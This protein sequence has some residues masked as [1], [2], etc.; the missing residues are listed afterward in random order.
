MVVVVGEIEGMVKHG[1]AVLTKF[2]GRKKGNEESHFRVALGFAS[3]AFFL[4]LGRKI[5]D[6]TEYQSCQG[7]RIT[8]WISAQFRPV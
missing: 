3:G 5:A 7:V 4:V 1:S 8:V 2:A 6:E